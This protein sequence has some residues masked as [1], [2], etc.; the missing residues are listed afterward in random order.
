MHGLADTIKGPDFKRGQRGIGPPLGQ[1]R[2]HDH[3]HGPKP[4]DLFQ[5]LQ[6]VHIGHLDI[7]RQDIG[8]E[9]LYRLAGL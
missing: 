7:Q 6:P 2:D 9:G 1:G 8:I 5:E 3:G 4:H